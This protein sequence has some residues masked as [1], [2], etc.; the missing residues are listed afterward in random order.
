MTFHIPGRQWI[1][2]INNEL[3][4]GPEGQRFATVPTE[5]L[6]KKTGHLTTLSNIIYGTKVMLI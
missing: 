3:Q 4:L 5:T 2:A 1:L 6:V